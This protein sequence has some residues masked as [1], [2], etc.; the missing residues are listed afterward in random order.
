[1]ASCTLIFAWDTLG[2]WA[3]H[4]ITF[5]QFVCMWYI[6]KSGYPFDHFQANNKE[7]RTDILSRQSGL[8]IL[9]CP[10]SPEMPCSYSVF[11]SGP[12]RL[13]LATSAGLQQSAIRAAT[14]R[15]LNR[16][17]SRPIHRLGFLFRS[18]ANIQVYG[19]CV[20]ISLITL[21]FPACRQSRYGPTT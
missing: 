12:L 1:M 3:T 17:I 14:N 2:N 15:S 16:S 9:V 19:V 10:I 8:S 6:R 5:R 13:C 7:G 21:N 4:L 11:R 18:H 20:D